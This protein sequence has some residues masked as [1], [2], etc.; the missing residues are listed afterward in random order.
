MDRPEHPQLKAEA[1]AMERLLKAGM[2]MV[3]ENAILRQK[4]AI[5]E[6]GL[7]ELLAFRPDVYTTSY[8]LAYET[9]RV[10]VNT[11]DRMA[12]VGKEA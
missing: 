6:E 4:V 7:A 10:V 5:A 12:A 1:D 2:A 3:K 11:F 9:N 8:T